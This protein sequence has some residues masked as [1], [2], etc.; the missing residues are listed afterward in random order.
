MPHQYERVAA[1][2]RRFGQDTPERPTVPSDEVIRNRCRW[3]LEETLE[4]LEACFGPESHGP[5]ESAASELAGVI[6]W[7]PVRVDMEA[8]ADAN[9][10]IRYV[11]YGNDIAA[12]I[13]SRETDAEVAR[14]ND[15]KSPPDAPG[16]KVAKGPSYSPPAIA[17]IL[18]E[19]GWQ[20]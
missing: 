18:R 13:D 14:S 3:L 5:I 4:L 11:A 1:F 6:R 16:G 7:S 19:Q 2:M 10:D 12:G 8:Y 15:S 9:A 17:A 20:R